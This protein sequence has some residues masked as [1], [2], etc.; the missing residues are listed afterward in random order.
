M[1]AWT[2][3]ATARW[4]LSPICVPTRCAL[5]PRLRLRPRPYCGALGRQL[6][7]QD[8]PQVEKP[9]RHRRAGRPRGHP[10]VYARADPRRGRAKHQRRHR[11]ALPPDLEPLYGQ[12]DGRLHSGHRLRVHHAGDYLFRASGFRVSFDASPR[13]TR[14]PP[15]TPKRRRP[16]C[17]RWRR[18][19][20][21]NSKS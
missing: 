9:L 15:T 1:K 3:R 6:R 8:R 11:K 10:P 7:L 4:V 18:A 14:N 17:P 20:P 16:P 2:L 13:C 19:R 21:S 5:P 12:P